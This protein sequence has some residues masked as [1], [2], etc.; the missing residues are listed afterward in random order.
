MLPLRPDF[1]V[2]GTR[3][4]LRTNFFPVRTPP[5]PLY[6][7]AV[8]MVPVA[9]VIRRI[10]RRVLCLAEHTAAWRQAGMRGNV[11]HDGHE[12]L[13]SAVQLPQPLTIVVP[14]YNEGQTGPPQQGGVVYTL[15]IN[16][17]QQFNMANL[18][19]S[20]AFLCDLN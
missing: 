14:Y 2:N 7:Y 13:V 3:I 5:G 1:G 8:H 19:R 4:A 12:R 18:A 17:I 16:F 6:E 15:S 9:A 11:A 10:Q 20:V